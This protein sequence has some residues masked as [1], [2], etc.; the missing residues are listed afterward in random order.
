[1]FDLTTLIPFFLALMA[2]QLSPGPDMLLVLGRGIGQG[3]RVAI[4]TAAGTTLV[5][6]LVQLPLLAL[7]VASLVQAWPVAF[8]ILRWTGAAYL[9][10]VGAR[11]VLQARGSPGGMAAGQPVPDWTA[12]REGMISNLT[13]P[14]VLMFMLAF[15][16]QFVDPRSGWSVAAQLLAL[17]AIQ[18]LSGFAVLAT[19]AIGAGG[20]GGRLS[21]RPHL[22]AWQKRFAGAVMIG[23]GIRLALG[24][25]V[26]PARI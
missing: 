9:V 12:L 3:R 21:R 25:D 19:V 15:L 10:W 17:G 13:N 24:G 18:K 6:G 7:G 4:L 26:R 8:D 5:A 22:I 20:L 11:L 2:L 23:L 16:P 14:K 1:M